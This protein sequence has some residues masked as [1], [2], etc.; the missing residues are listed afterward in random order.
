ISDVSYE[1][2]APGEKV[3][4]LNPYGSWYYDLPGKEMDLAMEMKSVREKTLDLNIDVDIHLGWNP[5]PLPIKVSASLAFSYKDHKINTHSTSKM[6]CYP[7]ILKKVTSF[8]DGVTTTTEHLAFDP[9]TGQ[10]LLTK[11][12]DGFDEERIDG[13]THDGS[14]YALNLPAAWYYPEMG[15][16]SASPQNANQLTAPGVS[17]VSYGASGNPLSDANRSWLTDEIRNVA[18]ASAQTYSKG[19][20]AKSNIQENLRQDFPELNTDVENTL[21]N[22]WRPEASYVYR[23]NTQS[24]NAPGGAIYKDGLI[25]TL[26]FFDTWD[27]TNVDEK[28][29][30]SNRV[31]E[32]SPNGIPIEERNILDIPSAARYGYL[33]MMPTMVAANAEYSNIFFQDYE[34]IYNPGLIVGDTNAFAHTGNRSLF[35]ADTLQTIISGL[36]NSP[37]LRSNPL[38][39]SQGGALVNLWVRTR[40][41]PDFQLLIN[42]DNSQAIPLDFVA[43]TG[44]WALLET[45][46]PSQIFDN[47]NLDSEISLQILGSQALIDQGIYID[48]VKFQPR[49]SQATCYVYDIATLRLIAQFDDQHFA[50]LYQYDAEGKLIRK[51]IETERGLKTVTETQ[52]NI[53]SIL[54]DE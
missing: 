43:R 9:N 46:L 36:R 19:W 6:V 49:N 54:R 40:T 15:P 7:T 12:Q 8:Q 29:L 24:A 14:I 2:Y 18:Q 26:S 45:Y 34:Q 27:N 42:N 20:F 10:P 16:K 11:T 51:L 13:V 4:M 52:Y 35:L 50:L 3:K 30:L 5:S 22:F 41:K 32:Y 38:D 21:N 25:D 1:Y 31:A 33:N 23:D 48:D 17:I 39:V 44:E 47:L 37:R 53:P 28:W